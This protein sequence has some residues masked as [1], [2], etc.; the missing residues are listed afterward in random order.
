MKPKKSKKRNPADDT[1]RNRRATRKKILT[2]TQRVANIEAAQKEMASI[3]QD[4]IDGKYRPKMF[5][6]EWQK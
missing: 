4:I 1:G 3:I 5:I 6:S 2:L